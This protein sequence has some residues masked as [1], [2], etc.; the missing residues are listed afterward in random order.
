MNYTLKQQDKGTFKIDA[1]FFKDGK[2]YRK[3]CTFTGTERQANRKGS[4]MVRE[5]EAKADN[6][7]PAGSL[8]F[9]TFG[10]CVQFY[11]ETNKKAQTKSFKNS[12]TYI[13][14]LESELGSV[15]IGE[16]ST[17][18]NRFVSFLSRSRTRKGTRYS[19]GTKNR[20]QQW[21]MAVLNFA[22]AKDKIEENPIKQIEK[23]EENP[24][25]RRITDSEIKRLLE[26]IR[27][28]RPYL[29]AI[30]LFALQVPSRVGELTKL[31]R[32]DCDL[33][34]LNLR[35]RVETTKGKKG[36]NKP[37]PLDMVSYFRSIP[38]ECPWVF[39]REENGEY[40]Q[41]KNFNKAWRFV[42]DVA[43]IE[44]L[45][46]HDL[47]HHSATRLVNAGLPERVIMTVAGWST[48]MLSRYYGEDGSKAS[49]AVQETLSTMVSAG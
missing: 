17:S 35:I 8:T 41:L 26:A 22:V 27:K 6:D 4:E 9:T 2:Q 46:F 24:R 15:S 28:H 48:N 40:H 47:R 18:L 1:R 38:L 23:F 44:N 49:K 29:E 16:I 33:Q 3:R 39:Y 12:Y 30:T 36:F 45:T 7:I 5:L 13:K 42:C 32:V 14:R 43:G 21:A 19:A 34:N 10:Q 11:L 25:D 31:R 37:I 20:Y